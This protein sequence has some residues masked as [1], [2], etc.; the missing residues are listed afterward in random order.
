MIESLSAAFETLFTVEALTTFLVLTALETVLGFD[1]LLYIS[2]EAKKAGPTNE[3]RV[4]R[5]GLTLAIVFRIVLLIVILQ[6]INLF[7][8]PFVEFASP[9]L[10]FEL[11]G[12]ALIVLL[13]G[14]FLIWTALKEIF[15]MIGDPHLQNGEGLKARKFSSVASVLVMITLMNLVFSFDTVLSAVALTDNLIVMIAAILISGAL[16]ILMSDA[17]A[18]FLQKN[19][20]YEVLG[21]FV[22]LLV[23]ILLLG[24]GG[25]L[26]HLHFFGY[27]VTPMSKATFYFVLGVLVL[28]EIVQGRYQKKILR[29]Q[30][31]RQRVDDDIR[32]RPVIPARS[33]AGR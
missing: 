25:H 16:M 3:V 13:G 21:L 2:L 17:V 20:M 15:H 11:S 27:E 9:Y 32:T 18:R 22:L 24:E 19:R 33:A 12:H 26:A 30:E 28:V 31:Q 6:L 1:N 4:R 23:G 14:L 29:E 5:I 7:K 10:D 8:D